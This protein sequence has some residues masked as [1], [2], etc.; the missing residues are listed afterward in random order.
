MAIAQT[1]MGYFQSAGKIIVVIA[2]WSIFA[3]IAIGITVVLLKIKQYKHYKALIWKRKTDK[4]GNEFPVFVEM[5]GGAIIKDR[6]LKKRVFKLKKNNCH[7]GVEEGLNFDENR[8]L[9]IPSVP[10]ERGGEVVFIEKLGPKKFAMGKAFVVDGTV[11]I[12]VSE[13][14]CAE[15]IRAYDIN[16]KYYGGKE[17]TKWIGPISFAVFAIL[18]IVLI[19]AF[20]Q[21]IEVLDIFSQRMVEAARILQAGKSSAVPS[22][23]A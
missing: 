4:D 22:G 23:V 13:A 10:S 16:A 1:I 18:I 20:L 8:N 2:M 21:K 14:D 9:D 19:I 3:G 5:D 6:K 15:A 11:K 17:W 12:M 7:L